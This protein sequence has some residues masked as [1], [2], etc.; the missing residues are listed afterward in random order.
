MSDNFNTLLWEIAENSPALQKAFIDSFTSNKADYCIPTG[1][2]CIDVFK[3]GNEEQREKLLPIIEKAQTLT[4]KELSNILGELSIAL[5]I[6]DIKGE[7][8][9]DQEKT[10]KDIDITALATWAVVKWLTNIDHTERS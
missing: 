5:T 9:T 2:I 10:L 3:P 8:L 7:P 1:N 6:K 4:I